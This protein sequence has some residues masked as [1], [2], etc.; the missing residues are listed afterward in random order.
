MKFF[1]NRPIDSFIDYGKGVSNNRG[2]HQPLPGGWNPFF[3]L[4]QPQIF[5]DQFISDGNALML[6]DSSAVTKGDFNFL[7]NSPHP[8]FRKIKISAYDPFPFDRRIFKSKE[9]ILQS[10]FA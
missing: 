5:E 9:D 6:N 2:E 3:S 7:I 1:W 8:G 4:K 10:L